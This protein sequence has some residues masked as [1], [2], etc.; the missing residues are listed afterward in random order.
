MCFTLVKHIKDSL[1]FSPN[2]QLSF[3]QRAFHFFG[4]SSLMF[5]IELILDEASWEL[6][7]CQISAIIRP[8]RFE[9]N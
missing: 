1:R 8:F 4:A 9:A 2:L 7:A 6:A 5:E 3:I